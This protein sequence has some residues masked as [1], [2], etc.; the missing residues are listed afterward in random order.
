VKI[1][2]RED[3]RIPEW[4]A[5]RD[6]LVTDM[7][8]EGRKAAE[9]QLYKEILPRHEVVYSEGLQKLLAGKAGEEARWP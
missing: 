4:T 5:V 7:R 8:F 6:R 1:T 9:D 2:H 3:S